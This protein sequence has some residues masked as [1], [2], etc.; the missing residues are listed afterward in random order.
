VAKKEP[1]KEEILY[2]INKT[3][4]KEFIDCHFAVD[5]LKIALS[6]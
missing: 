6:Q 2:L 3:N 1:L 4:N 5:A